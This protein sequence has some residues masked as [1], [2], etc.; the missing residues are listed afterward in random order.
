MHTTIAA[1]SDQVPSLSQRALESVIIHI[2]YTEV[3]KVSLEF[4]NGANGHLMMWY[5]AVSTAASCCIGT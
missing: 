2:S 5:T 4:V 3:N 1:L